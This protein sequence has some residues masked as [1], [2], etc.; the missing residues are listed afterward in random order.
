[1]SLE[2]LQLFERAGP[3]VAI[4]QM[5]DESDADQALVHV[6][7]KRASTGPIVQWPAKTMLHQA[8][9]MSPRLNLPELLD[10]DAK[11]GRVPIGAQLISI[12]ERLAQAAARAFG[13]QRIACTQLDTARPARLLPPIPADSHV[14]G[15]DADDLIA[16]AV[17]ELHTREARVQLHAER[18]GLARQ[19][20]THLPE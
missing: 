4:V 2:A 16:R 17:E 19:P 20:A 10:A 8:G 12:N 15:G 9:T 7:E 13:K 14:A 5:H 18:L 11:L 3:C 6:I 1:M